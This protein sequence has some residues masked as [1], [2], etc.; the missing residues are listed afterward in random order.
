MTI[1]MKIIDALQK[2][3]WVVSKRMAGKRIEMRKTGTGHNFYV[4]SKGS[5]RRGE[6]LSA[7]IPVSEGLVR[8]LLAR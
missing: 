8:K 1:Q 2:D 5:L 6:T 3:G 4:G 7:S